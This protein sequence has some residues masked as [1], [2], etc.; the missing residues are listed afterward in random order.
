MKPKEFTKNQKVRVIYG[1]DGMHIKDDDVY[2]LMQ[3]YANQQL[4]LHG[5][6]SSLPTKQ[7]MEIRLETL[8]EYKEDSFKTEYDKIT[9]K[10][11][12]RTCFNWLSKRKTK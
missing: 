9:F 11:G 3:K 8:M 6:V 7:E 12:F 10:F 5:V 2:E 4:I 1:F